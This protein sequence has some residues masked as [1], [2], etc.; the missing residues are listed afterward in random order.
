MGLAVLWPACAFGTEAVAPAREIGVCPF[1]PGEKLVYRL[2]WGGIPAGEATLEVLPQTTVGCTQAQHVVLS[3]RTVGIVDLIYRVRTRI[4]SFFDLAGQRSLLYV[5]DQLEGRREYHVRA[6][7]DWDRNHAV[8]VNSGKER[9]PTAI[10]PNTLDPLAVLY[11]LRS[12][13]G[14][15]P[16]RTL[17]ASVSDGKECVIGTGRVLRTETATTRL[18]RF[19]T[20]VVAPDMAQ[21]GGVFEKSP[22]ASLHVWLTCD[23]RRLPVR[24][25][26]KVAIG[27]FVG[28]LVE[29]R[30][31]DGQYLRGVRITSPDSGVPC[32]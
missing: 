11:L 1:Q 19:E 18:G 27:H 8:C 31:G 12:W 6:T 10:V 29:A 30:L 20:V 13:P 17:R 9:A 24:V 22:G 25:T 32:Q 16:G 2:S 7:F 28:E 3:A 23:A 4:E 26:S 21:V 15:V 14:V 5:K